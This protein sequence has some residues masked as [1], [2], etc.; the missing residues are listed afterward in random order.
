MPHIKI[1]TDRFGDSIGPTITTTK[2]VANSVL[3]A[4]LD[5]ILGAVPGWGRHIRTPCAVIV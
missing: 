3:K 2:L 5:P 4:I 1:I